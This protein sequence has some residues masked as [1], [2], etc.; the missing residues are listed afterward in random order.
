MKIMVVT[1][2]GSKKNGKPMEAYNLYKSSR[3]KAVYNRKGKNDMYILSAKYGLIKSDSIIEP[4]NMM[5]SEKRSK[6]LENE[7]LPIIQKYDLILFFAGGANYHYKNCIENAALKTNKKI[8]SIGYGFMGDFQKFTNLI[9]FY[10]NK[11]N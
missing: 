11:I 4:Y 10:S 3:I 1:S 8:I 9:D 2:C 7:L 6:E 5:M